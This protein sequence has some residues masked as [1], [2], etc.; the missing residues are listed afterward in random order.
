MLKIFK[1]GTFRKEDNLYNNFHKHTHYSNISTPDCIIKPKHIAERTKEISSNI[2]STVEHGY[3]GNIF[4]YHN[5]AQEYGLKL[6]HGAE[7]YFVKDR[8]KKDKNNTHIVI[9]AKNNEGYQEVNWLISESNFSGFYYRNRIDL[10]LMLQTNPENIMVTTACINN[11]FRL[12][13]YENEILKPLLKHF[14]ENLYLEIH[15]NVHINQKKHNETV[16]HLHKKYGIPLIHGSDTHYINPEDYEHRD[17]LLK[18]KNIQYDDEEG[19]ILDFPDYK[20]IL[21]RYKKQNIIPK[22]KVEEALKSTLILDDFEDISLSSNLDKKTIKIPHHYKDRPDKDPNDYLKEIIR[23]EWKKEKQNIPKQKHKEYVDRIKYELDII[24]ET[25]MAEYFNLNYKI[26]KRAKELGGI[27]TKSSRGSSPSFYINRLLGFTG[28]DALNSPIPLYPTRFM[29][30]S[31]ILES[32][33]LPDIDF[34]TADPQPFVEASKEILGEDNVYIMIA[35]GTMKESESFR[36]LC[37]SYDLPVKDYNEVAKNI[38]YYKDNQKW[39]DLITESEKYIGVIDSA[40]PHPCAFLLLDKPISSNVGVF[41]INNEYCALIDSYFSEVYKYLKNDFL[42]V[43]VWKIISEVF[44]I[45]NKP[46]PDVNELIE[47]LD[48]KVWKLYEDGITATLNQVSTETSTQQVMQYKPK[49]VAELSAFVAAIRPSFKSMLNTFLNREEF[50]YGIPEFDKILQSSNN[51]CLYQENI[52][53]TLIFAGFKED[54]TYT[55]MKKIAKKRPDDIE[56]IKDEFI[57]NFTEKTNSEENAY[58]LWEIIED[59]VNYGFNASHALSVALDSL[60]GAYL[61]ANYPLEY[62]TVVLNLYEKNTE[63]TN[64]IYKELP[65]FDIEVKSIQFGKSKSDYNADKEN[66][67]IYKGL[68]SIKTLNKKIAEELYEL[69]KNHYEDF[70]SLLVDIAEKTS[71]NKTQMEVLIKLNFF[72]KFG[73][74]LKLLTVYNEFKSG[75]NKYSKTHKENTKQKRIEFLKEYETSIPDKRMNISEQIL[76][77]YNYVGYAYTKKPILEKD[78][79][80]ILNIDTKYAPK[81]NLYNIKTGEE[82]LCKISRKLFYTPKGKPNIIIG[83]IVRIEIEKQNKK[84]KT[85]EGF[86]KLEEKEDWIKR[87]SIL[88][89]NNEK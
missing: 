41:K 22:N 88:K 20:T 51:F 64:K 15:D 1:N 52:M 37:R 4:D 84:K 48:H 8:R 42:S 16:M 19:F 35:Y 70:T 28:I 60:Y 79:W 65:Y 5:T 14:K 73:K 13:N 89:N 31:R 34:N 71:V 87:I 43:T 39:K 46:I 67:I 82:R 25:G 68:N 59:A 17:K 66:K 75:K 44:Y 49:S 33:N 86:I 21:K 77:E 74:N 10:D 23:A 32:G 63:M 85:E 11:F 76:F 40:S 47:M 6:V 2:L 9:L 50:S 53:A 36:N 78:Y 26:I 27:L 61:K 12:E 54:L 80:I 55:I 62:Y 18:G 24:K 56:S 7:F 57:Q 69:S 58:K 3:G 30:V 45:I 29:S 38:E 83:D 81:V 72:N